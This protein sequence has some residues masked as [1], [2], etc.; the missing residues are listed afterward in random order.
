MDLK[1]AICEKLITS[2]VPW[3]P[4]VKDSNGVNF[5]QFKGSD[6]V[7]CED[8]YKKYQKLFKLYREVE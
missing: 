1:C 2:K 3:N 8:C 7:I 6:V 5:H 4:E